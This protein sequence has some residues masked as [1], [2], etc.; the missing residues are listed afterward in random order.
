MTWHGIYSSMSKNKFILRMQYIPMEGKE[1]YCL[2]L[3]NHLSKKRSTHNTHE[4][5]DSDDDDDGEI[6][7]M[8]MMMYEIHLGNMQSIQI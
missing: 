6:M 1:H 8:M 2:S 4:D 7:K 5:D 3:P